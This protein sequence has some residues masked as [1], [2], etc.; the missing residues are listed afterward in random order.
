MRFDE[1]LNPLHRLS[2]KP[3]PRIRILNVD[4]SA[5]QQSISVVRLNGYGP[6]KQ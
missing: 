4:T 2:G 3:K 1:V 5:V 6:A